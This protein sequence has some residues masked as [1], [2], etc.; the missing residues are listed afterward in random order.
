MARYCVSADGIRQARQEHLKGRG[1]QN[2]Q[3]GMSQVRR[4]LRLAGPGLEKWRRPRAEVGEGG[5]GQWE[6]Q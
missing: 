3:V 1:T 4:V 5:D 2:R 6:V